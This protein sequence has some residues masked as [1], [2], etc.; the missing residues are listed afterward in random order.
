[1]TSHPEP[2]RKHESASKPESSRYRLPG[3]A[4]PQHARNAEPARNDP[5]PMNTAMSDCLRVCQDCAWCCLQTITHCLSLGGE[6]AASHHQAVLHDCAD[7]CETTARFIARQS[8]HSTHLC[9]ECA[10]ICTACAR[11]CDRMRDSD[12]V[13]THCAQTC[14]LC[15]ESCL[16]LTSH[17]GEG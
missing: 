7:I 1:M 2:S 12:T 3:K 16:A 17:G 14:R 13:M 8:P 15:A 10:E 4:K 5:L 11:E 9:R 6:H